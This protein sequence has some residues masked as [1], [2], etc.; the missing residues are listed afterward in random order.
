MLNATQIWHVAKMGSV[1]RICHAA[2]MA[3]VIRR[4]HVA[5]TGSVIRIWLILLIKPVAKSNSL[6]RPGTGRPYFNLL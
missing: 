3:S 5:K 1:I 2:R 4:W 6:G